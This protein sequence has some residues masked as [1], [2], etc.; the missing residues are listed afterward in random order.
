LRGLDLESKT[1]D[2]STIKIAR[3]FYEEIV[4]DA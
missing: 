1:A 3:E 2:G 4:D